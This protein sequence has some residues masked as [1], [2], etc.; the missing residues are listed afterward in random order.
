MTAINDL[1]D[2]LNNNEDLQPLF[3][4]VK[5]IME[6]PEESLTD[7]RVIDSISGMITGAFTPQIQANAVQEIIKGLEI[8]N[9]PRA[10]AQQSFDDFHDA[11]NDMVNDLKPSPAKRT[12]L[13]NTLDTLFGIFD[14]AME[15]YHKFDIVLPIKLD[16]DA[17]T[18]TYAHDT[19][20]A[21]DLYAV[22]D[23]TI[24]AHSLSNLIDTGVH[25]QLPENWVAYVIPRSS[26]GLK[27]GLR[28]SNSVGCIDADY[29]N[30]IGV[31]YDNISDSDYEIHAGDR[32]AQLIVMPCYHFKPQVV[33]ILNT[34]ERGNGGYGSTGK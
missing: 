27:T 16:G 23:M 24:P 21:A 3:D 7:D 32:I 5:E 4:I 6:L 33:D 13:N 9:V 10:Q 2:A 14:S 26:I 28:L 8:N 22:E 18:P 11:L 20:A 29:R 15:R 17:K 19:D 25:I 12:I 30:S 1:A 34:T 31:I